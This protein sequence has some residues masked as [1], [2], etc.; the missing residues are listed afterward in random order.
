MYVMLLC[1]IIFESIIQGN[2]CSVKY[3]LKAIV[4]MIIELAINRDFSEYEFKSILEVEVPN[5]F[6][7]KSPHNAMEKDPLKL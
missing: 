2:R 3:D 4:A 7:N 6:L 1:S 5:Y